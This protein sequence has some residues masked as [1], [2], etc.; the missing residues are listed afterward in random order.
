MR[1]GNLR[2]GRLLRRTRNIA[3]VGI[4]GL[5]AVGGLAGGIAIG[6]S[7]P[8]SRAGEVVGLGASAVVSGG[9]S[10]DGCGGGFDTRADS[11]PT[12]I[13]TTPVVLASAPLVRACTG[14]VYATYEMQIFNLI[15]GGVFARARATCTGGGCGAGTVFLAENNDYILVGPLTAG[16]ETHPRIFIFPNLPAGN[17]TIDILA[18]TTNSAASIRERTLIVQEQNGARAPLPCPRGVLIC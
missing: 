12:I 6:Q 17:Y 1:L 2:A 9:A 5:A 18:G 3:L 11:T 8:P 16:Y 15:S 14:P 4:I 13:A 7:D 10:L